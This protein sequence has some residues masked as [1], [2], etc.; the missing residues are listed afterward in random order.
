M[1]DGGPT[2][3]A[4]LPEVLPTEPV[5]A[6][7]SAVPGW[8]SMWETEAGTE[9]SAMAIFLTDAGAF[10]PDL[11]ERIWTS[12]AEGLA[13]SYTTVLDPETYESLRTVAAD[14]GYRDPGGTVPSLVLRLAVRMDS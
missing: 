8:W 1:A 12:L 14:H 11:A 3:A 6:I 9:L 7:E 4:S 10:R 5:P 13:A 2:A